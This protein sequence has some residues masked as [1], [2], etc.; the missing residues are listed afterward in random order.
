MGWRFKSSSHSLP[1]LYNGADFANTDM[2]LAL[3][4]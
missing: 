4:A 1:L 2:Q 3:C